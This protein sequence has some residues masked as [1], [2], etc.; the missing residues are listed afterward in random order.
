[1]LYIWAL[2]GTSTTL[3][4][5][6]VSEFA[7]LHAVAKIIDHFEALRG[8]NKIPAGQFEQLVRQ[9]RLTAQQA[10]VCRLHL[11][12]RGFVIT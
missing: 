5:R 12:E 9:H 11:L 4:M 2:A 8:T 6:D 1:M 3:A 10:T 7:Y